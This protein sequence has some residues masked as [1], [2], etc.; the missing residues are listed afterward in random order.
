[1]LNEHASLLIRVALHPWQ[2]ETPTLSTNTLLFTNVLT[3][4]RT[5]RS[6]VVGRPGF[7]MVT[8]ESWGTPASY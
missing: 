3:G 1:L 2:H 8:K 4:G 7:T 6:A 5:Y